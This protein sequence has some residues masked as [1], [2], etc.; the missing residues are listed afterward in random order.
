[1]A[2]SKAVPFSTVLF[3]RF[4]LCSKTAVHLIDEI[5]DS[6]H[7]SAQNFL[8]RRDAIERAEGHSEPCARRA[9]TVIGKTENVLHQRRQRCELLLMDMRGAEA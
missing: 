3:Q 1:M 5:A 2:A 4:A 7:I 8:A 6:P 9:Q